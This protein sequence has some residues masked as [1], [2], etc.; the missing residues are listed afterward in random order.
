MEFTRTTPL[1]IVL[2]ASLFQSKDLAGGYAVAGAGDT[3]SSGDDKGKTGGG[4]ERESKCG[5]GKCGQGKK[6][7]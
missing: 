5:E 2:G 4:K 7:E 1:S 3:G 6:K